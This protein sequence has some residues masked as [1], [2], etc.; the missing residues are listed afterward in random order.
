MLKASWEPKME[1]P[2]SYPRGGMGQSDEGF[3]RR[4]IEDG[5]LARR[6]L[7]KFGIGAPGK[8]SEPHTRG[9]DFQ[10]GEA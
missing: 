10:G 3:F 4:L 8:A 6:T 7:L 1:I 5:Q 2:D 9:A